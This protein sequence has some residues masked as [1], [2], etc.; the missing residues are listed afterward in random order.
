[1]GI[2]CPWGGIAHHQAAE[3]TPPPPSVLQAEAA[4]LG[5]LSEGTH[6]FVNASPC[7]L[8]ADALPL[9]GARLCFEAG[10]L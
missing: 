4:K 10:V 3:R 7:E 8:P 5:H 6:T 2:G 9:A 1:M